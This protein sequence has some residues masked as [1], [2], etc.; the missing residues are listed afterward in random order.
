MASDLRRYMQ[1]CRDCAMSK[2]PRHL[3]SGKL[4]SL[5]VPNLP[6]SHLG[7][8]FIT[9]LLVSKHLSIS[10]GRRSGCLPGTSV[11]VNH[12]SLAV[13]QPNPPSHS[14]WPTELPTGGFKESIIVPVTKKTHPASL[15]DYHPVA[16][17]SV[18]MKCL[19]RLVRDF[20]ISSLPDT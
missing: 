20:I 6:W 4:L 8:D 3:P 12:A 18:V 9:D 14:Y 7:V 5:P 1:G 19:E 13:T 11:Y 17:T 16:L 2:N 10:L 15:N